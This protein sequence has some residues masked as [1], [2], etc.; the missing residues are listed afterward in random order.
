MMKAE[1]VPSPEKTLSTATTEPRD[2]NEQELRTQTSWNAQYIPSKQI[3]VQKFV[4]QGVLPL[5]RVCIF[6]WPRNTCESKVILQFV[7]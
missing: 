4:A 5:Q 7:F 6:K 2:I 3:Q 1:R